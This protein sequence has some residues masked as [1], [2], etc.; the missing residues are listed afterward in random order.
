MAI[1]N[2]KILYDKSISVREAAK[3]MGVSPS[4]VYLKRKA[5]SE[6]HEIDWCKK[7]VLS[8]DDLKLLEDKNL[9]NNDILL[10]LLDKDIEVSLSTI[11]KIRREMKLNREIGN[12][13]GYAKV[14]KLFTEEEICKVIATS[15]SKAEACRRL[16]C[17]IYSYNKLE[18]KYKDKISELVIDKW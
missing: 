9:S 12:K 17:S 18:K 8:K 2:D 14:N 3:L 6:K 13:S 7:I 4:F 5:Y 15:K 10:K 1:I 16:K 11:G